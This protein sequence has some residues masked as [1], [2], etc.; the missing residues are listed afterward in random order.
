MTTKYIVTDDLIDSTL[1]AS[2]T[3]AIQNQAVY[4]SLQNKKDTYTD[5]VVL[6]V[7]GWTATKTQV[8]ACSH[9]TA[10]NT[11]IVSPDPASTPDYSSAKVYATAQAAGTLTFTCDTIPTTVLTV[12][13]ISMGA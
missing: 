2:S 9:A 11:I 12:N 5:V 3:N 1:S 13:V 10:T 4:N 7:S 6:T 8:V